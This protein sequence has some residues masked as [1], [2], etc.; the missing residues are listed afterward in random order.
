MITMATC[1]ETH[2]NQGNDP[3]STTSWARR[4]PTDQLP[5]KVRNFKVFKK[6]R[7][8]GHLIT[9]LLSMLNPIRL[10]FKAA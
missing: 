9:L 6:D 10:K 3:A 4:R 7:L 2:S 8:K 1:P 5:S